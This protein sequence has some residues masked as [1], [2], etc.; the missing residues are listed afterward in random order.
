[1]TV[2]KAAMIVD[3]AREFEQTL[4]IYKCASARRGNLYTFS[5]NNP[6]TYVD[7]DGRDVLPSSQETQL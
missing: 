5:G 6:I 1:M 2:E 7:P 4:S 3:S